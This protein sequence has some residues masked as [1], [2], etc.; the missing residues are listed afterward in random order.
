MGHGQIKP[1]KYTD[2]CFDRL[3]SLNI[4]TTKKRLKNNQETEPVK[5]VKE[6]F[7]H[8]FNKLLKNEIQLR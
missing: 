4:L 3:R 6:V 7:L 1:P 2:F 5:A 8:F